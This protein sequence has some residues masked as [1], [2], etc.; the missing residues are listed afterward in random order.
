MFRLGFKRVI[1]K[2]GR[3]TTRWRALSERYSMTFLSPPIGL[4]TQ[5]L[6]FPHPPSNA[7][8]PQDTGYIQQLIG[9]EYDTD[10]IVRTTV[11]LDTPR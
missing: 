1:V 9:R 11:L 3:V 7:L 2:D 8:L 4:L 10:A 5:S 6:K